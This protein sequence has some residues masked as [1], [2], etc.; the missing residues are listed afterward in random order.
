MGCPQTRYADILK[1]MP[2]IEN[3]SP[4][5][6][7]P[8]ITT[9]HGNDAALAASAL[10]GRFPHCGAIMPSWKRGNQTLQPVASGG[11]AQF[12]PSVRNEISPVRLKTTF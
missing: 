11:L 2:W 5:D 9:P 3:T 1:T 10:R 8:L 4:H 12:A 6:T 7:F